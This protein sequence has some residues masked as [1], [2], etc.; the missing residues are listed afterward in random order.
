MGVLQLGFGGADNPH[1][2]ENLVENMIAYP[3]THDNDTLLGWWRDQPP[4]Q[5]LDLDGAEGE[6]ERTV[7]KALIDRV[8]KTR[9][10]MAVLPIQDLLIRGSEARFNVPGTTDD[11]WA[12]RLGQDD[13]I[14]LSTDSVRSQLRDSERLYPQAHKS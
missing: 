9:P 1:A 7:V 5:R 10:R 13:L 6:D 11:N 4:E 12:W 2:P 8:L 14:K 3:G